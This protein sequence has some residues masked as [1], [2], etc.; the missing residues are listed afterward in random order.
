MLV[1]YLGITLSIILVGI[2][3]YGLTNS[4]NIIRILLSSEIILNA[5]IL[6]VFA[7]SSIMGRTY[8]PIIFSIFAIGMALTE[9]IVAFAAIIL[10]FRQKGSLEVE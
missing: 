8:L 5:S 3:I 7:V 9:V 6:F 1:S 2:G 4:K 10:Y